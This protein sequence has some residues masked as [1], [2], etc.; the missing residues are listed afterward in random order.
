MLT[1]MYRLI[2]HSKLYIL[3]TVLYANDSYLLRMDV[4]VRSSKEEIYRP[5]L[6][7]K[8]ISTSEV[9]NLQ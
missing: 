4:L 3:T 5:V 1:Y 2:Q 8:D 7:I 9:Q 6:E